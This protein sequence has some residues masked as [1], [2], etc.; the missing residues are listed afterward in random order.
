M[1]LHDNIFN[2]FCNI[3]FSTSLKMLML[4]Q[5]NVYCGYCSFH[6]LLFSVKSI[7]PLMY[8]LRDVYTFY[9]RA[10]V[11]TVASDDD[12]GIKVTSNL[13]TKETMNIS[14]TNYVDAAV[15]ATIMIARTWYIELRYTSA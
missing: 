9:R 11:A 8:P 3:K 7:V 1:A 2:F 10:K 6:L 12:D 13:M 4:L 14:S 15:S 5:L